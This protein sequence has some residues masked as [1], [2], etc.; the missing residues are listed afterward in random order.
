MTP[1]PLVVTVAAG[2]AGAA[3]LAVPAVRPA[4]P[5]ASTAGGVAARPGA[6]MRARIPVTPV[7]GGTPS[8]AV[9]GPAALAVTRP[10][11]PAAR[12]RWPLSPS[13]EVVRRFAVGPQ[14]W[15]PG[16]RGVDLGGATGQ[17]V[18]AAG[19]GIVAFAGVVAGRGVVT[20]AHRG[21]LR[22]TYEPVTAEVRVGD[23][24]AA[25][26]ELGVLA[27]GSHCPTTCLHWGALRGK[28]YLDPLSLLRPPA[29]PI[30]LP[31]GVA[32]PGSG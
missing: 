16:H 31:L 4:P 13:P 22:T 19:A 7:A 8:P 24:V 11:A 20:V 28:V 3:L 30:L 21:G 26:D 12:F 32:P 6:H 18:L 9:A 14:P 10:V 15:S 1:A 17:A 29:P 23:A 25:G 5:S 2:L 27:T